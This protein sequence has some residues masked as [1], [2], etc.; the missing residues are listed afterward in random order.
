MASSLIELYTVTEFGKIIISSIFHIIGLASAIA[1][2]PSALIQIKN[3]KKLFNKNLNIITQQLE[4]F[5]PE[6]EI[7]KEKLAVLNKTKTNKKTKKE[8]SVEIDNNEID[9]IQEIRRKI[10]FYEELKAQINSKCGKQ[11][12]ISRNI[13]N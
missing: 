9:V 6:L 12:V 7:E 13:K 10:E 8:L 5:E 1:L 3:N 4:E 11:K 2:I